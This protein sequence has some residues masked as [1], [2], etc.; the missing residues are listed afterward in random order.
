MTIVQLVRLEPKASRCVR[1]RPF[2][3]SDGDGPYK[4]PK[5]IKDRLATALAAFRNAEE[6][7]L[8][9]VLIGRYWS[10]PSRIVDA[11]PLD[12]R[13]LAGRTDLD[14]MTENKVRGAIRTLE[15]IGFIDRAIP[16][17]GSRYRQ[18]GDELHRKAILF[19]FGAEYGPLFGAANQRMRRAHDR[20]L[21]DTRSVP[22]PSTTAKTA[23]MNSPKSKIPSERKVLMGEQPQ[24]VMSAAKSDP[25]MEAALKRFE[26][27]FRGRA[28]KETPDSGSSRLSDA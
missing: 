22:L 5:E 3:P 15:K 18:K 20:R 2:T 16:A 1:R 12:R 25:K 27:A 21:K 10:T 26:E 9:A 24:K 23:V 4:L 17:K 19:R 8:L 6:A 14:G 7:Y 13:A 28:A 11:F